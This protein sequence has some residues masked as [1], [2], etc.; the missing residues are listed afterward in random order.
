MGPY[1]PNGIPHLGLVDFYL[2]SK[3]WRPQWNM[4]MDDDNIVVVNTL[5]AA[6][7]KETATIVTECP[8]F[9]SLG[10]FNKKIINRHWECI[11]LSSSCFVFF[12]NFFFFLVSLPHVKNE[13]CPQL[14]WTHYLKC[15]GLLN[16]Y[17]RMVE[18]S[19]ADDCQPSRSGR[20]SFG[21]TLR[22]ANQISLTWAIQQWRQPCHIHKGSVWYSW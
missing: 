10:R 2:F 5:A 8:W 15:R 18:G 7:R 11:V 4:M 21:P 3:W 20:S 16:H 22:P 1:L 13:L 6:C 14:W 12:L 17:V 19:E 9:A